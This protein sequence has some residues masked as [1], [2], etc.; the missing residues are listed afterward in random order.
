MSD[1]E[2]KKKQQQRIYDWISSKTK[3][4]KASKIIGVSLWPTSS[5]D[6]NPLHYAKLGDIETKRMQ[7]PHPLF[8]VQSNVSWKNYLYIQLPQQVRVYTMSFLG[9]ELRTNLNMRN[10]NK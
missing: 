4:K 7:I 8:W 1:Q 6:F 3:T 5:L 9:V 2:K 10:C